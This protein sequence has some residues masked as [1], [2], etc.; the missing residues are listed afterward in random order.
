MSLG[1]DRNLYML[2]FD[3]RASF[4]KGLFGVEGAAS[5]EEAARIGKSK[6]IIFEGLRRAIEQGAPRQWAGLLVDEQFGADVA[7]AAKKE[8]LTLAMPVEKSGQD[9]FDFEFGEDFGS[10]IEAFDPAFTKVLVRY[11]PEG[12]QAMNHRQQARLRQLSEWLR[13][14]DRKFL[15]ELLVPPEPAQLQKVDGDK[16]RYDREV[17]P[18]LVVRVIEESQSAHVEPDIWKIEGL[19]RREDCQRVAVQARSGGRDDVSCIVLGRG[20]N[21]ERVVHWLQQGAGVPGFVGFAVGRTIWWDPLK[22]WV[23]GQIDAESAAR[24][25]GG[26][27]RRM[28]DAYEAAAT[29]ASA[30]R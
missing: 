13:A 2:A 16:D 28:A 7:R 10:H 18:G 9:E 11:N 12:D 4:Q 14:R 30:S 3:H 19:D 17:R 1:Y 22:S 23:G 21:E 6:Q 24:T 29:A 20:A 27:Y 25:I 26:N 5:P 8:G 15:F